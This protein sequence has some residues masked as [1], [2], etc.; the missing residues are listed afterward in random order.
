VIL[1][2]GRIVAG[3]VPAAA[4]DQPERQQDARH[5]SSRCHRAHRGTDAVV[6]VVSEEEGKISLVRE[7]RITRDL[8]AGVLR[9]TLQQLV[10]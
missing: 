7:G 6:I 1:H 8:D 2:Q 5:P 9:T 10:A 4:H 3:R